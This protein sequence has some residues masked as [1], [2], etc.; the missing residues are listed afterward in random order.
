MSTQPGLMYLD[1]AIHM[2]DRCREI[3]VLIISRPW[4]TGAGLSSGTHLLPLLL[5][6]VCLPALKLFYLDS[7]QL[8]VCSAFHAAWLFFL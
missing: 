1:K 4:T 6:D 5:C 7:Y 2:T 8:L 3:G